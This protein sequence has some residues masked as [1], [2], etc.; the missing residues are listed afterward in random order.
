MLAA[1]YLAA[2]DKTNSIRTSIISGLWTNSRG[3]AIA[4]APYQVKFI[5]INDLQGLIQS[6]S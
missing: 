6:K 1:T 5:K 4:I 3:M 2:A